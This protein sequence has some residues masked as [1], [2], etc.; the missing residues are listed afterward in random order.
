MLSKYEEKEKVTIYAAVESISERETKNGKS[1]IMLTLVADGKT[2]KCFKWDTTKKHLGI[3]V[4]DVVKADGRVNIYTKDNSRSFVIDNINVIKE[5]TQEMLNQIL[6]TMSKPDEDFY[7]KRIKK[8][9]GSIKDKDY[10][11]IARVVMNKY[12]KSFI[13]GTAAKSNHDAFVGGLLKHTV[14]VTDLA[15]AIAKHFG[16]AVDIDLILAGAILHDLGKIRSY[17]IG[18]GYI[19][20][21]SE[22][23]LLD[24]VF[25]T[26]DMI[27]EALIDK[28]VNEE[29][30]MLVKHIVV[31]H[32]GQK[33]WGALNE[34]SFPEAMIVH[35]ADMADCHV[36]MMQEATRDT[37]P[38]NLTDDRVWPYGRKL[39]RKKE[40]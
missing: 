15:V 37:E 31:S 4:K 8:L 1:Y 25:H 18:L 16:K 33:D 17:E 26:L 2:A 12:Y 19:D 23:T 20:Y 35:L 29:K 40:E 21:T 22:G 14:N 30:L 38:G 5:P 10:K 24:H 13:K 34:P 36:T 11:D 6:P 32:H 27:K 3:R 7:I 39:Y 9:M 28:S